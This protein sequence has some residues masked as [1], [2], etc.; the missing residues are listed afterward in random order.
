MEKKIYI[1]GEFYPWDEAKIRV[2]D[3]G[4]LY[5]DG[6]FEGIRSYNGRVFKLEEHIERLY[7]SAEAIELKVPIKREDLKEALLSTLAKNELFK[8]AY[9]RVVVTRGVGDLG[10]D[11]RK[12]PLG[13]VIIIADKI[14]IYPESAYLE[15]LKITL[16]KKTR[17]NLPSSIPPYIKSLNYLNNILAKL[18]ANAEGLPEVLLLNPVGIVTECS[19]DNIFFIKGKELFTS[20][21]WVGALPGITRQIVLDIAK[22]I[23]LETFEVPFN[24]YHLYSADE[25]FLTGTAAE[26]VPVV[27]IDKNKIGSSKPGEYTKK[28]M[29]KFRDL[30]QSGVKV[31]AK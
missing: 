29:A 20:P 25:V 27:E 10:L 13:S 5:G 22:S 11:P 14:S 18:E 26:V 17:R 6:V 3:H 15:G 30:T 4:L 7:R 12:C 2:L 19:G 24:L 21:L 8:D 16:A 31:E 23:G 9:I 28:I 1:D